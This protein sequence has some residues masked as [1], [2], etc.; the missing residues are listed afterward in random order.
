MRQTIEINPSAAPIS[1]KVAL[2]AFFRLADRWSLTN[3]Q[4]RVLLS[5]P[6]RTFYRWR[7][8]PEAAE[9][10]SNVLERLSLVVSIYADLHRIF[11]D[12]NPHANDWLRWPNDYLDG[13]TPLQRMLGGKMMDIIAVRGVVERGLVGL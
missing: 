10:D 6:E 3:Q 8:A 4:A 9:L 11:G 7:S 2:N 1:P 12:N 5:V 13:Q